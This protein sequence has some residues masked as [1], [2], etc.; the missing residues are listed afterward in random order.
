MKKVLLYILA[1]L[2]PCI[3]YAQD[4]T[5]YNVYTKKHYDE[6]TKNGLGVASSMIG[7]YGGFSYQRY[8]TIKDRLELTGFAF[9]SEDNDPDYPENETYASIGLEYHHLIYDYRDVRLFTLLGTGINY[10]ENLYERDWDFGNSNEVIGRSF[11]VGAGFVVEWLIKPFIINLDLGYRY[12]QTNEDAR[13]NNDKPYQHKVKAFE[14]S[15][16]GGLYFVF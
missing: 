5:Q 7:S 6:N 8:I 11:N 14:P 13:D 12:R 4:N 1:L 16:G 9:V 2:I 3:I 15:I 10:D